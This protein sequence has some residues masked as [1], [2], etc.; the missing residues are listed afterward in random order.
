MVSR[1]LI[2]ETNN[3]LQWNEN[4]D[5]LHK[6]YERKINKCIS[7]EGTS[8]YNPLWNNTKEIVIWNIAPSLFMKCDPVCDHILFSG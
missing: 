4:R 5:I 6:V 1:I 7:Y 2:K 3:N 8:I